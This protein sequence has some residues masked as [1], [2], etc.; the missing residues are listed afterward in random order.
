M[1][2]RITEDCVR[3]GGCI[4]ECP[5]GA[6][7]EGEADDISRI[8]SEKCDDCGICVTSFCC[9]AAAIMKG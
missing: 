2:Y 5:Q 9:P 4:D 8:D 3:C 6:I 7:I 1:A